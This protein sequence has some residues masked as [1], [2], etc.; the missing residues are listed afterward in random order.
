MT[1]EKARLCAKTVC[2][3]QNSQDS[4]RE[5]VRNSYKSV[6]KKE[7]T[8]ENWTK[9][10]KPKKRSDNQDIKICSIY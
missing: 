3:M 9:R 5:C 1:R 7:M 8:D 6:R 4:C 2:D 10:L